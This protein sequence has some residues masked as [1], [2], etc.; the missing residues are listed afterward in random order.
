MVTAPNCVSRAEIGAFVFEQ[1]DRI[2]RYTAKMRMLPKVSK[3]S[4]REKE[5]WR[6][7][8]RVAVN[9]MIDRV[10]AVYRFSY[11]RVYIRDVCSRWG[12]CSSLGNLSFGLRSCLLPDSL[13]EYLVAHELCHLREMNHSSRFWDLVSRVIPDYSFRRKEL[14]SF[15]HKIFDGGKL[16]D[17]SD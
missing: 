11:N 3:F 9:E 4:F 14:K 17:F 10:N 6:E 1:S 16:S 2:A 8:S 15:S 12:S 5:R 13:L 7:R